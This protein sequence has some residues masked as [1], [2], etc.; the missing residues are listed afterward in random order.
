MKIKH[1]DYKQSQGW[2][3]RAQQDALL[4][5]IA[6]CFKGI[7]AQHY[8]EKYFVVDDCFDRCLRLYV[9][10]E[11]VIGYCLLVFSRQN[12]DVVIRASAGFYPQ[13]RKGGNTFAFSFSKVLA[14]WLRHPWYTVFYADTMLSPAMYRAVAKRSAIVWPKP[15]S[16]LIEKQL[17]ERFNADGDVSSL[18]N[19]RCL[20]NTGRT[21]N[22]SEQDIAQFKRSEKPEIKYF[23]QL[24]PN[25]EQ[26]I[27][28]FVIIPFNLKQ[29]ILTLFK[30]FKSKLF[31]LAAN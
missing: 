7:D 29:L 17:F 31:S 30:S 21:T 26:G 4:G 13:Y 10:Q 19:L 5:L 24:N 2:L 23:T 15:N 12:S 6:S 1:I 9:D 25:F 22:Y 20:T 28:L 27:A 11:Q 18:N 8:F 14:Y 3:Q 16:T